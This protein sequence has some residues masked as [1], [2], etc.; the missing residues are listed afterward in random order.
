[1]ASFLANH[2]H[3]IKGAVSRGR[4]FVRQCCRQAALRVYGFTIKETRCEEE[5]LIFFIK[6]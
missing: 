2:N 6:G 5:R 4:R 1:M 3:S